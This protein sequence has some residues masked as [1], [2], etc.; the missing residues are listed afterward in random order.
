MYL[1]TTTAKINE[2]S[3]DDLTRLAPAIGATAPTEKASDRYSFVQT[4]EAINYLRDTGWI[5]VYAG[6]SNA[7]TRDKLHHTKHL[8]R[9]TRPDLMV[10]GHRMDLL[11]YN[12]HDTGSSFQLIG[13][14]FR[15]VCSNG[16][17]IG[18]KMAEFRHRHIGFDGSAFAG[19]ARQIGNHLGNVAGV[20]DDWNTIDMTEQERGVFAMAARELVTGGDENLVVRPESLLL[21]RRWDDRKKTDLWTTFNTVQENVIRGGV[22]VVDTE[23]RRARR[24]RA[25]K[26]IDKD[27]S[28]NQALW[29]LT[30]KMAELKT[31]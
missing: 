25:V 6:Q 21:P 12:S 11:M 14:V 20:I 13:G 16:L 28:L 27:K 17:V 10:G 8:V 2:L 9:F 31:A 5:P 15:F 19:S 30:Q 3:N 22:R 4:I 18:D 26:S 29:V 1:N 23:K 24:S 7:R